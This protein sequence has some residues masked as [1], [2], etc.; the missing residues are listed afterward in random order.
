MERNLRKRRN[1]TLEEIAE[2]CYPENLWIIISKKVYDVTEFQFMHPGGADLLLEYAGANATQPF[3][4]LHEHSDI[5][6]EIMERCYIGDV[7]ECDSQSDTSLDSTDTSVSIHLND[8][9]SSPSGSSDSGDEADQEASRE[10]SNNPSRSASGAGPSSDGP[11]SS[12][13]ASNSRNQSNGRLLSTDILTRL[14]ESV[15]TNKCG[16]CERKQGNDRSA[17]VF[18]FSLLA[19]GTILFYRL[20]RS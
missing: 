8:S 7:W 2:H 6:H 17:L 3:L 5:A 1:Y 18:T 19:V 4:A 16:V 10:P 12:G 11:S 15:Q 14:R 20:T 13:N 9:F